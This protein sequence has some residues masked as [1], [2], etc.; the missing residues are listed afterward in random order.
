MESR[1]L[2]FYWFLA[3]I[4]SLQAVGVILALVMR[5]APAATIYLHS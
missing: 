3:M 4:S 5:V 2:V 1:Y